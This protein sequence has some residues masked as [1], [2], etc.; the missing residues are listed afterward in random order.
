MGI[1]PLGAELF[2]VDGRTDVAK[3][4]VTFRKFA[5]ALNNGSG[6]CNTVFGLTVMFLLAITGQ[7]HL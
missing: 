5:N 7:D 3:V 2:H 1:R 4:I 6:A